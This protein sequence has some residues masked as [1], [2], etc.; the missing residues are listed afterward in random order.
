MVAQ[1]VYRGEYENNGFSEVRELIASFLLLFLPASFLLAL[2]FYAFSNQTREYE[3]QTILLREEL[4]LNDASILT[5]LLF[6]Q[7]LSDLMV[8]TEGEVLR[9]YLHDQSLKNWTHVAREFSLLARRKPNFFQVR[10]IANDGREMVRINNRE[11]GQEIVPHGEL[12]DKGNRYYFRETIKLKAGNIYLSPLD[13]NI[14]HG[15][16][17]QPIKPT[18][19]FATPAF[20]GYGKKQGIVIINYTPDELLQGVAGHLKALQGDA[21]MLNSEGYW[22]QGGP[23]GRQW[24]FM[25]GSDDTFAKR[26]PDVW[27]A[28]SSSKGGT[29]FSNDG[30]YIFQKAYPLDQ[31]NLGTLENIAA[32]TAAAIDSG[33]EKRYWI[34]LSYISNDL[35]EELTAK[36]ALI[37]SVNYL[38]LF[39]VVGVIS[40]LFARNSVQKK[41]AFRKL[42]LYATTDDLTGLANRRELDKVALREF[43][44]ALRFSRDLTIL[45]F[46]LDHFKAV[47]DNYGH[48]IGDRVLRHVADICANLIRGQDFLARYG[49][50][51]FTILLP[52]T[53][54]DSGSRLGQRICDE[55]AANPFQHGQHL[56]SQTVSIGASEIEEGDEE[57]DNLIYRADKALYEAKKRGRNQVVCSAAGSFFSHLAMI[58][59]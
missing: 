46:D 27:A 41:L 1:T 34:Y 49:G 11:S 53:D 26:K 23:Q 24:G 15:K 54:L 32:S 42:Q 57:V 31:Q 39:L 50:E 38:L 44:R 13:L 22:L 20:D 2:I 56:I 55:I 28:I 4:A 5:S 9:S 3:L 37:A 25:Y 10:Y 8:L 59:E 21:M 18:I 47:N 33:K 36:R 40:A 58:N 48:N 51:E 52:E 45:M 16:I 17:E 30:V 35:V 7:K 12:Q 6:E 14:E 43:K 29:Y 19:R